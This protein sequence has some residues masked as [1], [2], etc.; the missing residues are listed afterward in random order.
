MIAFE[1][2][3]EKDSVIIAVN[4]GRFDKTLKINNDYIDLYNNKEYKGEATV[5][6][7]EFLI[8]EKQK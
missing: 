1:R 2:I 4:A 6:A 8:L 7:G 3:G 5:R